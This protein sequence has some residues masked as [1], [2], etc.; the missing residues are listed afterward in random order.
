MVGDGV[1]DA[2]ALAQGTSAGNGKR[3]RRRDEASDLT[4]VTATSVRRADAIRLARRTLGP[5]KT[6]LFWAFAYNVAAIPWPPP[7]SSTRYRGRS[8][9]LSRA[10]SSSRTRCACAVPRSADS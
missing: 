1:N 10:C 5:I 4:L 7:G 8:H 6:N 2:P 3:D 9:W